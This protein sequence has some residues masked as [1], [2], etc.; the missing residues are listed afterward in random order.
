M[1]L[2]QAYLEDRQLRWV[3][4]RAIPLDCSDN[5]GRDTREYELFK[6]IAGQKLYG[7]S[8]YWGLISWKFEHKC[9][10]P[11]AD[12]ADYCA[13]RFAEGYDCTFINPM[14]GNEAFF[15]NV[16]E[17][18]TYAH[19]GMEQIAL[20]LHRTLGYR[21]KRWMSRDC[22]A[23]CNYFVANEKFWTAYFAFVDAALQNLEREARQRSPIGMIYQ[24][25]AGYGMDPCVT[26]RPFV[27]E[28]LLSTFLVSD[29]GLKIASYP[30]S[31]SHYQKKF[32]RQ[33]GDLMHELSTIKKAGLAQ[34]PG[35]K[36][37]VFFEDVGAISGAEPSPPDH[38]RN[39]GRGRKPFL[40]STGVSILTFDDTAPFF[41][42]DDYLAFREAADSTSV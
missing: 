26:M 23:M 12:F 25:N 28:R 8:E 15:M 9:Q 32:G 7:D 16:W 38:L 4:D 31:Q 36:D 41:L 13:D 27:I 40:T 34:I 33:M 30:F 11:V 21:T 37:G 24:G 42:S 35:G 19:R 3:S 1:K 18:G 14:I 6:K 22:F 29:H 5:I 10:I 20:Y 39:W 17:Q 2:F